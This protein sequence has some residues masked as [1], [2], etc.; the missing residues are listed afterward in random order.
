MSV[1]GQGAHACL[2]AVDNWYRTFPQQTHKSVII[3][4]DSGVGK[5]HLVSVLCRHYGIT[6]YEVDTTT[7]ASIARSM[8]NV[9]NDQ[10]VFRGSRM[11]RARVALSLDLCTAVDKTLVHVLAAATAATPVFCTYTG[12]AVPTRYKKLAYV[13]KL[14]PPSVGEVRRFL[15]Q[16]QR[17]RRIPASAAMISRIADTARGDLMQASIAL[18]HQSHAKD[19]RADTE[20]SL[21]RIFSGTWSTV[22][23]EREREYGKSLHKQLYRLY[24]TKLTAMEDVALVADGFSASQLVSEFNQY[25]RCNEIPG[26][27]IAL[28]AC[29]INQFVWQRKQRK[30]KRRQLRLDELWK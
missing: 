16:I 24:P 27:T 1:V 15:T 25:H 7:G 20:Q 26:L 19:T 5:T 12:D 4:G 3:Y 6:I 30:E 11:V 17:E 18:Q 23:A 10:T 13:V 29:L 2:V 21:G 8:V 14:S 28:T 22:F 9:R